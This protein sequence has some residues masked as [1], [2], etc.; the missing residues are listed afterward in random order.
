MARA[1]DRSS[2]IRTSQVQVRT[3]LI[4]THRGSS[5]HGKNI[6]LLHDDAGNI[7][8]APAY[9]TVP[10]TT[11]PK[12]RATSAVSVDGRIDFAEITVGRIAAEASTWG[13]DTEHANGVATQT[14]EA[15]VDSD[16]DSIQSADLAKAIAKRA[17]VLLS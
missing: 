15:V 4:T 9:D 3:V 13:L 11:W 8:L 12:L 7:S 14:V 17:K 1:R 2:D 6:S 5:L 10:T 16:P